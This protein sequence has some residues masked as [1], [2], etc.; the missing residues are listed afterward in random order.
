[1]IKMLTQKA[2]ESRAQISFTSLEDLVPQDHL[3][4][5]LDKAIDFSFVYEELKDSYSLDNGRPSID[6]VVLFKIVMIQYMFDI[7]SMRETIRQIEVNNAYRWYIGYDLNEPIP[8]FSTF[9]KN[10]TRRFK[11][12]GIFE[13]IFEEIIQQAI[14]HGF[15]DTSAVFIDS[16]H[17]KANANKNKYIKAAVQKDVRSYQKELEEEIEKERAEHGKR[18]FKKKLNKEDTKEIKQS[19]TDPDSGLFHKSD[20][21]KCFAYSAHTACDANNF[22]LGF[23]ITAGNVHDSMAFDE[24]YEQITSK[25]KE[26]ESVVV[27]AG[28][29]TPAICRKIIKDNKNPVIPYKRPMTS[30][31][32]FKKY[33]YVYDEYY[34]CYICPNDKILTYTTTNRKGYREYSSKPEDC[35]NCEHRNQCT[36]SKNHIKVVTR[37]IWQEYLDEAEHLR[38]TDMNKILYKMR[39]ETIE[40]VFADAKEKHRMRYTRYRGRNKVKMEISLIYSCMNLKKLA[41]WL[42]KSGLSSFLRFYQPC[43]W[44]RIYTIYV[45]EPFQAFA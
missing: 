32:F 23:D 28:Y 3:V 37:H 41:R 21:E 35:R 27:D 34:D 31:G 45:K 30:K 11:D 17:V 25:Y 5:E 22:I 19:T 15:I 10:Y 38:H 29:K 16:T 42:S 4:R 2:K 43:F 40:R 7:R 20:K 36:H 1:M 18:P 39:S 6:P 8:H 13:C 9:G 33:E 44:E 14:A 26:I 24:L 12:T